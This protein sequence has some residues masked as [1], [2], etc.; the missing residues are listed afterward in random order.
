M[1]VRQEGQVA[2]FI[3]GIWGGTRAQVFVRL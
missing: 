3:V 1:A 2:G